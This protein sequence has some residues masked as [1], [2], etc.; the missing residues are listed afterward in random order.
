MRSLLFFFLFLGRGWTLANS[1]LPVSFHRYLPT[2]P[3]QAN[4]HGQFLVLEILAKRQIRGSS[5][6]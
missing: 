6:L 5:R 2:K 1:I 3:S 4:Q